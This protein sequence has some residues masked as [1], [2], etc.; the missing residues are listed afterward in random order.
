[1]LWLDRLIENMPHDVLQM[2]TI[3]FPD[4]WFKKKHAKRRMVN[5]ELVATIVNKLASGGRIFVQTDIEFLAEEMFELFRV[6]RATRETRRRESFPGQRPSVRRQWR[7]RTC[8]SYRAICSAK[9]RVSPLGVDSKRRL[10]T[11]F[12]S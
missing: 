7:T 2:V 10:T 3:H 5:A 4:P 6:G 8:R 1:M 12:P 9:L 11:S